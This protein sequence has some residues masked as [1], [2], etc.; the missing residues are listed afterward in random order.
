MSKGFTLRDKAFTGGNNEPENW[1]WINSVLSV[2]LE[3]TTASLNDKEKRH[4]VD[5][6]YSV[7]SIS[8]RNMFF[9]TSTFYQTL[10]KIHV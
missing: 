8:K 1:H 3:N 10:Q 7:T 9:L 5:T 4:E 2:L 6:V